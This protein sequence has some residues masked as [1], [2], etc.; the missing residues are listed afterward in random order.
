MWLI[1]N[2][3]GKLQSCSANCGASPALIRK[4]GLIPR[5][6]FGSRF[7]PRRL[8][9]KP[10]LTRRPERHI[11]ATRSR[12]YRKNDNYFVEQKNYDAIRKTVRYFRFDTRGEREA[13][14][15]VYRYLC[16]LYN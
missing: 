11:R 9:N 5:R 2:Y 7:A 8:I 1:F 3:N 15:E 13:L 14:A 16:P 12:P 4:S 6:T 10:L